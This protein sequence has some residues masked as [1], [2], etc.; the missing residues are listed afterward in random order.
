MDRQ[1]RESNLGAR[2]VVQGMLLGAHLA[3]RHFPVSRQ[4]SRLHG[5][6]VSAREPRSKLVVWPQVSWQR[7]Q[8]SEWKALRAEPKGY[9]STT[10][11]LLLHPQE[12]KVPSCGFYVPRDLFPQSFH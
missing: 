8:D 5:Y 3:V 10:S 7:R 11:P 6:A 12:A 4:R 9:F 1:P 2:A